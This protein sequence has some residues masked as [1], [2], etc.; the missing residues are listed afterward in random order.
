MRIIQ[1][2]L[3]I[4]FSVSVGLAQYSISGKVVNDNGEPLIQATVFLTDTYY[5]AITEDDG[6]YIISDVE[7]GEYS[8]KVSYVGYSSYKE[9]L[10]V[11]SDQVINV[12][13]GDNLLQ[14]SDIEINANR[15]ES[16]AA[17]A[18]TNL[19]SETLAK[20]NLGQD[21]PFLLRWT[22]SAVVTSDAGTGIGYTGIRI[23]GSDATRVN[24]TIN[25][26]PLNDSESHT[27]FWVDLPDFMTSVDNVQIQ[28]GVGTSTNGAGAFGGTI[29]LNTNKLYQN[30]YA[31]V[32][33]SAGSFNT[34]KIS[35]S[36]G[37]GLLNDK[38]TIDGRYSIIKS[39]GFVDRASSDLKS[40][41]FSAAR[42]GDKSSLRLLAFSGHER[43]Y[44]SWN[45][46][47]ESK[48]T[49]SDED[50]QDYYDRN[51]WAF[52]KEDSINLFESDRSYNYYTYA[53]QVD[54]YQQDHYQ[55]HYN[56]AP[57]DKLKLK[58]SGFYTRGF[59][60]YE[61]FNRFD[62]VEGYPGSIP[63][64]LDSEGNPVESLDIVRRRWLDNDYFGVV[65]GSEYSPSGSLKFQLGGAVSNYLGDHYGNVVS[66]GDLEDLNLAN[67]YY[68]GRGDKLDANTY[69]KTNYRIG[70]FDL[71]GDLQYRIIN[72]EISGNDDDLTALDLKRDFKF[73]N[74][75]V[76]ITYIVNK[77][78]NAY[79]SLAVANK[80]P[81]RGDFIG[82]LDGTL[83]T[84]ETLYDFEAG[85]RLKNDKF[86]FEWNNY[87]ML[88]DN[89]LVPTGEVNNSGALIKTNVGTS[90]RI[91]A[92]VS[93]TTT[94]TDKLYWNVNAT[95][96][97]N[98]I[99]EFY[100]K[101]DTLIIQHNDT[102]ISYS[103]SV[104]AAN[105]FLYKPMKGL[106]IELSTKFVGKQ[107]L[108]NTSNES[109]K[110]PAY[111][112]SNVRVGYD[113]DPTFVGNVKFTAMVNNIFNAK[114]S[115]NGYTY[116]YYA[117][118]IVTENLVYPQAGIHFFLGV[119]V[120]F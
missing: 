106:D 51:A 13:L 119:N 34:R 20:E 27:V 63:E 111:S 56:L 68:E 49:G 77:N 22:P 109:R 44:Q 62:A 55:L 91:G 1:S 41:Y 46:A 117:G 89:Q 33:A 101:F 3:L 66:A 50:L 113:W 53:N 103:P 60:F 104:I 78:Q 120:E 5:A 31:H 115:S 36:L 112:F 105:S 76:G 116:S 93:L 54:D 97:S 18:H 73:F 2:I 42:M 75:K 99:K 87:V 16:D 96:S 24:T 9:E 108:D 17:F 7:A 61:E 82:N 57:S 92:E 23:R 38:Y 64:T 83:P 118:D 67:K 35:V 98:K 80:E 95:L 90:A 70:K 25:G 12:N 88:Y 58:A 29:S 84:Y 102:D 39:D 65:L 30:P 114:Y 43:T 110:L 8:L 40:W 52:S 21:V 85:Y 59:G 11:D 48:V 81:T 69:L 74:P 47:P 45:G 79:A 26:V 94:I 4:V 71:F 28:R 14:L 10:I 15:V 37:T 72:Y 19:S 6:S 107:Y 86:S 32:N 100:E